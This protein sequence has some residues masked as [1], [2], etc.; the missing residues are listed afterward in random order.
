MFVKHRKVKWRQIIP[1]FGSDD[2][3]VALV[4]RLDCS[5]ISTFCR[6]VNRFVCQRVMMGWN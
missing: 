4:Q 3:M 5:D 6:C 2:A 1:V